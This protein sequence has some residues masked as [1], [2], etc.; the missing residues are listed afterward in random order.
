[1]RSWLLGTHTWMPGNKQV[2]Y[3]F[4]LFTW[5]PFIPGDLSAVG[6]ILVACPKFMSTRTPN[7]NHSGVSA[8]GFQGNSPKMRWSWIRVGLKYKNSCHRHREGKKMCKDRQKSEQ[9]NFKLERA[10]K[11]MRTGEGR[12]QILLRASRKNQSLLSPWPWTSGLQNC[13]KTSLGCLETPCSWQ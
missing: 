10:R 2:L 6:W 7:R 3:S 4:L 13:D 9:W 1:M 5:C 8:D 12:E 11:E